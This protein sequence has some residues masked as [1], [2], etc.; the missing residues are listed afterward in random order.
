MLKVK[1]WI[2]FRENAKSTIEISNCSE[3]EYYISL[4][5]SVF[6]GRRPGTMLLVAEILITARVLTFFEM[7]TLAP[8]QRAVAKVNTNF[9]SKYLVTICVGHF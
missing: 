8:T 3:I 2:F 7:F 9:V 5:M 1:N 4:V 6:P